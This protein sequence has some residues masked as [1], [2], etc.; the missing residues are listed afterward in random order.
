MTIGVRMT[1]ARGAECR[2]T[3]VSF[4]DD[5]PSTKAC[6]SQL[7]ACSRNVSKAYAFV[8]E[9]L[10]NCRKATGVGTL[11][12]ENNPANF[13]QSPR[14]CLHVDGGHFAAVCFV[15]DGDAITSLTDSQCN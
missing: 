14:G 15:S 1:F 11:L 7:L 8:V 12:E 13:Y 9:N 4:E 5:G 6:L 3:A 2:G 10:N